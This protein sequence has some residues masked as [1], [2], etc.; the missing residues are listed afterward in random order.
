MKKSFILLFAAFMALTSCNSK[1]T[2]DAPAPAEE[3]QTPEGTLSK[4]LSDGTVV[5]WL[6]D[7]QGDRLMARALF[8]APDSL[9]DALGIGQD[10]VPASVSTYVM[11]SGNDIVLFDAGLGVNGGGQTVALLEALGIKTTDVNYLYVSHFHGDHIGGMIN[12]GQVV[13]PN[14]KVYVGKVEYDAWMAMPEDRNGQVREIMGA[15]K[16]QLNFFEFDDVLPN[17]VKAINA[18][19]HTPGHTVFQKAELL[20]IADLMHGAALQMEHPEYNANFD[21]D[22]EQAAASRA[23]I[24]EYVKANNL[25]MAGMHLPAPGFWE[26]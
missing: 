15:Y 26:K 13:F 6:K 14:A 23:R 20:I 11:K 1:K 18:V 9:Y 25:M 3:V 21:M 8:G 7:N 2:N 5:T 17:G 16:D 12:D 24:L 22:K 4:T 19:G 10:G